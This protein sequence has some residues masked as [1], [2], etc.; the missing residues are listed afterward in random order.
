M[1]WSEYQRAA[2]RTQG[3]H[4]LSDRLA[5]AGLG[6]TG[7]AGEV[8]DHLKKHLFQGHELDREALKKELGDILWYV[9]LLLDTT[10][11]TMSEILDAN[12]EKLTR[13]YP[14]G[15]SAEASSGRTE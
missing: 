14:D 3:A 6:L 7:E 2:M 13:R 11:L 10:G 4:D 1:D 8:A 9:A 15:F 12:I 5:M